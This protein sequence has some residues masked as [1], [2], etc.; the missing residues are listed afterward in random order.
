MT[1]T[2]STHSRDDSPVPR[3]LCLYLIGIAMLAAMLTTAGHA[4]AVTSP[5]KTSVDR[6]AR[7]KPHLGGTVVPP[8]I[9]PLNFV[10]LEPGG[11]YTVRLHG[12]HGNPIDLA[13]RQ[14]VVELPARRWRDLLA[15][16]RGGSLHLDMSVQNDSGQW[17][18][19]QSVS[20]GV[21]QEEIDSHLV[22]RF[23]K[24]LHNWWKDVAIYQRNLEAF[25]R[26][27]VLN[28]NTFG[29]GCVNCHSF[30][31]NAPDR[32][33]IGIRSAVHGSAT[34]LAEPDRVNKIGAKWGYTAW[35]PQGNLAAYSI[36]KVHQFFHTGA[37][38]VRDVVDLDSAILYYSLDTQ[39]V[40]TAPGLS[41]P[42]RLETYPTWSPDGKYLY[43]CSAPIL[44]SDRQ[45]VPPMRYDKVKYD[46]MR[47]RFNIEQDTW[48]EP[49]T[50]LSAEQTGLSILLPRISPDGRFL[51]CSMCEYGCFPI[52]Q[53]SSDLYR[54]DLQTGAYRRMD[55]NSRFAESWHSFSSNGRWLAF[56]SKRRG[57]LFTRT[58]ITYLDKNGKEHKPFI[59]PQLDPTYYDSCLQ[60]FSVPELITGPV[61]VRQRKLAKA[62]TQ[63]KTIEITLPITGATPKASVSGGP[64]RERE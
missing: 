44:W 40:Q 55:C 43:F 12:A 23:I 36:N 15:A 16:N 34:L 18:A 52:Y 10:I 27:V 41:D 9:A 11:R 21:A 59:L 19:F 13:T 45:T 56:S 58:F 35:H 46:L 5:G 22:Y 8:N 6:P 37:A 38:E 25:D 39:Q 29:D 62:I 3:C 30:Q 57:G 54:V 26:S 60:T 4:E 47:I 42:Q 33:F 49:E 24:P 20:F 53:P 1:R 2:R 64:Y 17:T 48:G 63:D 7:L 51:V 61:K 28:G 14:A 32:M 50:V 31:N